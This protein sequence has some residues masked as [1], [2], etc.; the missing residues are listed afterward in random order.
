LLTCEPEAK[1]FPFAYF[2]LV[3]YVLLTDSDF[4]Q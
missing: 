2:T 3:K 4:T 1:N